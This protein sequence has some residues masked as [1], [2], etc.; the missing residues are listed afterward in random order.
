VRLHEK[1]GHHPLCPRGVEKPAFAVF[2]DASG[3]D[4]GAQ[5]LCEF[6]TPPPKTE[7]FWA[8][9]DANRPGKEGEL[10]D[11]FDTMLSPK[12]FPLKALQDQ[13]KGTSLAWWMSD[14]KNRRIIPHRL[15][16]CGYERVR[17]PDAVD[18]LWKIDGKRQVVYAQAS[19]PLSERIKVACEMAS[20][21]V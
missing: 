17:N 20:R 4:I 8:I 18:G 5:R 10:A 2:G 9:V 16:K 1:G 11:V 13:A 12:A 7:A 19:L 15:E 3:V 6:K 14:R 21:S